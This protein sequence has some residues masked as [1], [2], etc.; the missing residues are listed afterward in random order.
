MFKKL[1]DLLVPIALALPITAHSA[2]YYVSS[3]SG[4][5]ANDG[6]SKA[7]PWQTLDK[8]SSVQFA[9]NSTILFKRG[10][11]FRGTISLQR[12]PQGL[13]FGAYGSGNNPI[14]AGS[15]QIT[16]WTK[17]THPKLGSQVY[18]ADVSAFI[19]EDSKGNINTIEHLFVNGEL[20]TIARYPNVDSPAE[21]NWLQVE[22]SAGTDAFTDPVL[23]A[24]KKPDGYW[25]GAML[26]IRTYSWFYKVF[27][28]TGYT[29]S[30]GKIRAKGLGEQLPEW[31]YFLDDK[32]EELDHPGE[33]YYDAEAKKVYLYPKKGTN[34]NNLLVEGSTYKTGIKT[35]DNATIENLT[36][37][38][39]K[40]GA[41]VSS[42]NVTVRNCHF[43][44]NT[45]GLTVWNSANV[46]ITGNTF[47]HHLSKTIGL[48]ASSDFDVQNSVIEKNQITNTGMF[49]VYCSR[50]QGVCYGIGI[51][52]F[53]K[54]YTVRQNTV[55][56]SGWNGIYLKDGGYHTI[57]NNVVRKSLQLLNDG[58][59]ISIGSDGNTIR[60]NILL[61]SVGNVDES[62]GCGD[63]N[64]TPCFHH[65]SYGMGIGADP[66]YK[67]NVIEGNTVANHPDMG[68]R[69]NAFIN[70][71]V[72]NNVVYN[73]DPL[74]VVQDKKGPSRNNV[75]EG[76]I[77]YSLHPDQ[78]GL[79]LANATNHGTFDN[80]FYCNPY[81][82]VVFK[83][84]GKK[85]SLAHWKNK[86]SSYDQKSKWCGLHFEEY[87]ASNVGTD[88]IANSTFEAD[89]SNWSG[90]TF[91]PKSSKWIT[92]LFHD[93]TQAKMD[94]G[95]L[96]VVFKAETKIGP[97]NFDLVENQFYRFKFSVIGTG[98]GNLQLRI[99]NV[100][101]GTVIL[102][103]RAFAYDTN[104]KDYE[105]F[106]QSPVTTSSGKLLFST[107]DYD[108]K[109]YWLDNVS[110]EPV[111]ATLLDATKKSVLFLNETENDKTISLG[112]KTYLDL[113]GKT[114]TGSITLAPFSS[115]ILIFTGNTP[116]ST[117]QFTLTLSK[118]GSGN[119]T[120]TAPTGLGNGINCGT[121]CTENYAKDS[122][123]TLTATPD[124]G[125][126]FAG[127]S[128]ANCSESFSITADMNCTAT[129]NKIS[130]P[131]TVNYTLTLQKDGTGS[132]SVSSEPTGIDCGSDC[133]QS[134]QSGT[135]LKLTATPDNGSTFAGWSGANC[136]ESFT[137]T[138]DMNCTA[139]FNKVSPP[140]TVNYTLTLQKDG[141]GS[142]S[143]SSEPTG[144]DCGSDCTQRY[145]SDTALKLTATPDSGST[146]AGWSG[147]N[148]SESFT[149]TADM[150]CTATFNKVSPPPTVNY[151]LTLQKDGTGS[152]KVNSEPTGIDCGSDCTQSYQSGTALKLTATPDS[153]STFAGWS[154]ANCSESFTITADMNCTATFNKVSPPPT[155]NYTLTLQ[156]DGT[157]SGSVSSEPT[158]IDC[159]SDCTQRYQ[160]DTAL[161]LT[162]TPDSG[163][164]FAGWSGANCSESFTITADM[165]CT[166]TF[167]KVSP[168][169]TVNYTLTLQKDGTGSGKVNSEPTGI[170]CG[171]DCTQSY[172]S[173]TALKLT[174][175]PDSGSTFA[176]WSGANCSES[177]SI[178]ADMNCTATFNK[179]SPP[180]TVNYTLTLQKDGTGSGKV[181]S[182]PTGIDCGADCTEDYLSGTTVTL[183]VSPE[184]DSTFT[185]WS[186]AC[187]GTERS[188]TVT[189][190]AA[191]DCTANLALK[192]YTLTVTKMGDGN[193]TSQPTGID[194]GETCTANYPTGTTITLMATPTIDTQFIGF[195]G[196]ADCTDGQITLNTAVNC[197]ANFDLVIAL[198]F[199]IPA[200][201]TTGFIND[202][203][204]GQRQ[205][206]LTNVSVGENGRVSNIDLEGTITNK[207][208]ISNVIIKPNASLS[209]GIVTGYIINQGS[210]SDFEFR[211]EQ[212]DGGI[213]SGAIT[214]SNGG[215]IKNVQLKTN[216]HISGGKVCDLFGEIEAPALLEN[217][218]VQTGC[219]L[220]GVI[221][222]DNV[223][224]PD[225]VKLTN[226]TIGKDGQV[227]NVEL[228]GTVTNN[229]VVSNAT[230]KS[231]ATLSGGMVNGDITNQGTMSDFKFSGEKLTGGTLSGVI[232]NTQGGTIKNVQL[233]TNAHLSGG[234]VCDIFGD[235]EAPALLENLK[236]QA[237]CELSGVI[238]GDNVQLPDD[239]KL[240]KG[241][242]VKNKTLIPKD[243][244]VIHLL[245]AL[246]NQLSC[247]DN[248]TRP[249]RVDLSKDVLHPSEGIL[250]AINNLPELKDNGWQL[251]QDALYGYLQLNIDTVR[252]AVQAVSIKRAA[253]DATAH[254]QLQDNQSIR[255]IT[256]TGLEVL[257]QPAVQAPCELQAALKGFGF[258]NLTVQT[259]GNFKISASQERWYSVRPDWA[260]VEV[261]ADTGLYSVEP[262]I[263]NG[264]SM[265]KQ[266][267]T[268]T[269]G[270]QREQNFYPAIA[271]PE[272]LYD[273]A[274]EVIESNRLVSF[275]LKD[276]RYHGVM[277]YLVSKSTQATT[278]KLQ[279]EPQPD[280][281]GDG[282]EDFVLLYPTG[283][284][285]ILFAVP[286]D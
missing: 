158:G 136:S 102:K 236:V 104:R 157:G 59:A 116:P 175:T 227:S 105:L 186:G 140:P 133:T 92:A 1:L 265:I 154:G 85:Y 11:V 6:L 238:I 34:P 245:P 196:D 202:I 74:I 88:L 224:L 60:G 237:G 54:A 48:Q 185:G 263:V 254:M 255:F 114:V 219:E 195:T 271:M 57:E 26:R 160:S 134:Y 76:N 137:I 230:I 69:L 153:G 198:P 156:K 283:E 250:N 103:Q 149:I 128:G 106:F 119:G 90:R 65:P 51:N 82:E 115:Q 72:R 201:P 117:T 132:G 226:I 252:L 247:A 205:Q 241:V 93:T 243:F 141:T 66:V 213:L 31:G 37:R 50:Y 282:I 270:K 188:T 277:D 228:E 279:V 276:Q 99:N 127:W 17:T 24:Y 284:Q 191:K 194:C 36:F 199:E 266:V 138:A 184:A 240:G 244:N 81:N 286:A 278:D 164:T 97:K 53:G 101:S 43:E 39:F 12:K 83:R 35:K 100:E 41:S 75:V 216:A 145:Q 107:L 13:I 32:L 135:A 47:N 222:G 8:V 281:N 5:D 239:V 121:D 217:I 78:I 62:N 187:S 280:I 46:L 2:T 235:I 180:P 19:V 272:A 210:M 218:K 229:G 91:D 262:P 14:I 200:C 67:N 261:A 42:E 249:E 214:N 38:H 126:T 258:P 56:N 148:C 182:E 260:S 27:E 16:G 52:V 79:S 63:L 94:G 131:P 29:A 181:S 146:F 174:A 259:N 268:D 269:N 179:V 61:E 256:D 124:S 203:C 130:P 98:F 96:K 77:I 248:V 18:E 49:P 155:V 197:V 80:N 253:T 144:I 251:T 207:G 70:T 45:T 223:Q 28:V 112:S 33:W 123:I 44:Y 21:K 58:G 84:D 170:D 192:H 152:G 25:K 147:A 206:T 73:S 129:F 190:D 178:T 7:T 183:T 23:A 40:T 142:G 55:E 68:I 20:M 242:R 71:I 221:I 231:S 143:V 139:T 113:N 267:F 161:K 163:S 151:T 212:L 189:L 275:K 120:V 273:L 246:S 168:P 87:R 176:G 111:K 125:S 64:K 150:N 171:S 167:N 30:N 209:G 159:G 208:W 215:T 285:Q 220:S 193:I 232:T 274:Q 15:V 108:A 177:F 118:T 3:S 22:K 165:N 169:P 211:G 225:D 173:G 172:Q 89:V 95:S 162:A 10:D 110:F 86:F 109:T 204:N 9:D 234:K 4:N 257:T 264:I 122:K 166:A 233:K